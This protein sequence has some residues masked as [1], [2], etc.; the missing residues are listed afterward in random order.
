MLRA[1]GARGL[2]IAA[3]ALAAV[4]VGQPA[5]VTR[6]AARDEGAADSGETSRA[7][8]TLGPATKASE[9]SLRLR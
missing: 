5:W 3:A 4:P 2:L 8:R 9:A 1:V 6:D 7:G